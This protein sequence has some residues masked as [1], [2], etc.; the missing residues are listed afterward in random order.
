[1][2][3]DKDL[4]LKYKLKYINLKKQMN[5][6][7]QKGGSSLH[8]LFRIGDR[9]ENIFTNQTGV[10][11]NLRYL[12]T[13]TGALQNLYTLNYDNGEVSTANDNAL[14]RQALSSSVYITPTSNIHTP[15]II[16]NVDPY[17]P[18]NP[19]N[20]Q[21]NPYNPLNPYNPYNLP[22]VYKPTVY[23]NDD[24]THKIP[25][26]S[27]RKSSRK[28]SRKTSSKSSKKSKKGSYRK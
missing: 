28:T 18:Y 17:N 22:T 7:N 3:N 15:T 27:S 16:Q 1:M 10:I 9:V 25:R 13:S 21:T 24:D 12:Q 11:T 26:K 4:Y 8:P 14:I 23:Y 2:E 6:S 20:P 19:Y 5:T